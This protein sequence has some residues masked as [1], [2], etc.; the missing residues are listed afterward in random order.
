M[1]PDALFALT[2]AGVLLLVAIV[3]LAAHHYLDGA[4]DQFLGLP[5]RPAA[6]KQVLTLVV[7][8]VAGVTL[9]WLLRD[10]VGLR[11]W[12]AAAC[13]VLGLSGLG[14]WQRLRELLAERGR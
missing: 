4:E 8:V 11:V 1:H 6:A 12:L 3:V 9:R 7:A 10:L 13:L 5:L 14:A 2:A